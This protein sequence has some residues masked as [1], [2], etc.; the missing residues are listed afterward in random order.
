MI[1]WNNPLTGPFLQSKGTKLYLVIRLNV[2]KAGSVGPLLAG[3]LLQYIGEVVRSVFGYRQASCVCLFSAAFGAL[4][5]RQP[6][7]SK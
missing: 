7:R 2:N 6:S 5:L 1:Y 4:A 3:S